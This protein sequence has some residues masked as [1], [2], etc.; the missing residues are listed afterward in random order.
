MD[1]AD[2]VEIAEGADVFRHLFG[3][4]E[5][6][7]VDYWDDVAFGIEGLRDFPVE[8]VVAASFPDAAL[9]GLSQD[10]DETLGLPDVPFAPGALGRGDRESSDL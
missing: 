5:L 7:V 6:E 2:P 9:Q 8:V 10:D 1:P 4:R 3:V